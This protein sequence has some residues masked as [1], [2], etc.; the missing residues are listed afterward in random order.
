MRVRS[1]WRKTETHGVRSQTE[2]T[3]LVV[4]QLR[5]EDNA[6]VED[7]RLSVYHRTTDPVELHSIVLNAM[8]K[9]HEE[10][11]VKMPALQHHNMLLLA[12]PASSSST[13]HPFGL[14][15][16]LVH[17]KATKLL[18]THWG[19]KGSSA[20]FLNIFLASFIASEGLVLA[21]RLSCDQDALTK[22]TD[23]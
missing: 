19:N 18:A 23:W 1:R 12:V 13:H 8:T 9:R 2:T 4:Y 22:F 20:F 11:K 15:D 16:K 14:V 10:Q 21:H 5:G 6:L 7:F 17:V 3:C